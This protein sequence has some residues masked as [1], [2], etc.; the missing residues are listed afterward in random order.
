MPAGLA[1]AKE[2]GAVVLHPFLLIPVGCGVEIPGD[3]QITPKYEAV[4]DWLT[5][6]NWRAGLKSKPLVPHGPFA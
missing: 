1:P 2:A 4:P 6:R 5:M 3:Q